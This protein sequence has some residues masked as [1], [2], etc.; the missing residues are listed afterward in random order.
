MFFKGKV[1]LDELISAFE[2]LGI[3]VDV[4]EAKHLLSRYIRYL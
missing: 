2:D 1:D 3:E 4:E